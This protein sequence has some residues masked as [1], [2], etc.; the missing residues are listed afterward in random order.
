[1]TAIVDLEG[2]AIIESSFPLLPITRLQ[3]KDTN[4]VTK[5]FKIPWPG[6]EYAGCIFSAKY[7]GVTRGIVKT[8]S[9]K[10]FRNSVAIDICTSVKNVSAKLVKNKIHMCG[11]NSEAL[12]IETAQHIVN[13][14]INIQKELDYIN[15]YVPERDEVIKW[16]IRE[17]KSDPYIINEETQE[18][19]ELA[20]GEIIRNSIIYDAQGHVKY[21][22]KEI[23]FRWEVGD[24]I[25][26]DNII[27]N[28][29]DS[30]II[31]L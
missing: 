18:I 25:N 31:V 21:N 24:N 22:Y 11:P 10:S 15:N 27:V 16:L 20:E 7:A 14:L 30:L 28:N 2:S 1:M 5:K 4:K 17:T 8:A 9:N 13:H 23:P 26:P 12:A 19:I 3:L 29:M 6:K